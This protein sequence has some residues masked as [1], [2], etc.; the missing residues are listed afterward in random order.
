MSLIVGLT[1]GIGC[2]KSTVANLL[3][4]R[5][6]FIIDTDEISHQLT[7]VG[8]DALPAIVSAFGR[9]YITD[10]GTLDR[11]RLRQCIFADPHAKAALEAILHPRILACV[12]EQLLRAHAYP[13]VVI[14]V[15]LLFNSPIYLQLVQ[16]ILVVDC[17]PHQQIERV[18]RRSGLPESEVRNIMSQQ[19][20]REER[21]RRADDV[22]VNAS[23]LEGLVSQV[24][25]LHAR[26]FSAK[27]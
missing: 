26:Y 15:P 8:G 3:R 19:T 6:A 18:M 14:V 13:Y 11:V 25:L 1:G 20:R 23:D 12:Q 4:E 9:A 2:G 21:L 22:L 5:G 17:D 7:A 10:I 24:D 27:S 16:R